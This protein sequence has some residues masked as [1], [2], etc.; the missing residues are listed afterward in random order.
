MTT[1]LKLNILAGGKQAT[2]DGNN[3]KNNNRCHIIR[4]INSRGK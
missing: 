2:E 4:L 1:P 3:I